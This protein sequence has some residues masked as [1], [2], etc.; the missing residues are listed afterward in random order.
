MLFVKVTDKVA[1]GCFVIV[2]VGV[3]VAVCVIVAVAVAEGIGVGVTVGGLTNALNRSLMGENRASRLRLIIFVKSH[4]Y[5]VA[6]TN[7]MPDNRK[8]L[9]C[10]TK[11]C[12]NRKASKLAAKPINP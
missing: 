1:V 12:L 9:N 6:P 5:N 4:K 8:V 11:T 7:R 2:P 10:G 3:K